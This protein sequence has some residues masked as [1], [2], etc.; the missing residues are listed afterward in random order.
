VPGEVKIKVEKTWPETEKAEK[1]GGGKRA[2]KD[3]STM[4]VR[5][6]GKERRPMNSHVLI[7]KY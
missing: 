1:R 4:P 5:E 2:L 6:S 7:T 3:L